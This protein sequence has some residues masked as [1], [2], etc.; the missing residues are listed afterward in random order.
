ML[1]GKLSGISRNEAKYLIEQ[2]SGKIINNINK[3][4]DYSS[5]G[6][7]PTTKKVNIAKELNIKVINQQDWMKMLNKVS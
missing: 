7:K 2:N 3:K 1:T 4:L 6:E 5:A